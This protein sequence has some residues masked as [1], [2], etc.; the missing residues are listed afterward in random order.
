M[1]RTNTGTRGL[2]SG[3]VLQNCRL[4]CHHPHKTGGKKQLPNLNWFWLA[5]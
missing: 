4:R 1:A 3:S 5:K 2:D